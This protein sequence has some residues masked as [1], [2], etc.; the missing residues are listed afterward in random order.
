MLLSLDELEAGGETAAE[1]CVIGAGAAGQ[2]VAKALADQGH[3]VLI[4]ESGGVDFDAAIQELNHADNIGLPYYDLH[5]ARLRFFGGTT[6]IWGGRTCRLDPIDFAVRDWVPL[7]GWPLTGEQLEPFY[8]QAEARLE[9]IS[10]HIGEHVLDRMRSVPQLDRDV[11]D[12]SYWQFD[13]HIDRF[14]AAYRDDILKH[15]RISVLTRATVTR[16]ETERGQVT[17]LRLANLAGRSASVTAKQFVLAC[18]GIENARLLM[19]N[20]LGGA[21]AGRCFMEHVHCRGGLIE[22]DKP[23]D[24]LRLGKS[25]RFKGSRFAAAIRPAEALQ[26]QEHILNASFTINARKPPGRKMGAFMTGFNFMRHSM[27]VPNKAWRKMW[28]ALKHSGTGFQEIAD[29]YR[30]WLLTRLTERNIYAVVRTEQSPNPDS[31][32]VIDPSCPD[33]LGLPRVQLD[34]RVQEIDKRTVRVT[35]EAFGR[36]LQRLGLGR[37]QPSPWLYDDS[38]P[39]EFDPLVS[40]NPIGGYHHMGTTRMSAD[41][42]LGVTDADARVHGLANL[43]VAGSSLFPTG[44]WANPTL[45]ILALAFRLA[46]HLHERLVTGERVGA[47]A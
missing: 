10:D 39:W 4:V 29:P 9:L 1:I 35:M 45:T 11:I 19:T 42:K 14:T 30:P 22:A 7:S 15:Q 27:A 25:I 21:M 47:T 16:I 34:W 31:R 24:V 36:E 26:R 23:I 18:G 43:H 28:Y 41:P 46:D 32:I 44:G 2:T 13:H 3:D 8:K 38:M 17:R 6:A 40:K 33:A 12:A 20:D 5:R 37:V